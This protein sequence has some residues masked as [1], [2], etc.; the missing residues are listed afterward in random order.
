MFPQIEPSNFRPNKIVLCFQYI[1]THD[2]FLMTHFSLFRE[3]ESC[4]HIAGLLYG[5]VDLSEK[6]ADGLHSS[7]SRECWWLKPGKRKLSPK[8]S[9]ELTFKKHKFCN[10]PIEKTNC[11]KK[12]NR[13]EIKV[14]PVNISNFAA[15]LSAG[16]TDAAWLYTHKNFIPKKSLVNV[17]SDKELPQLHSINF[18]YRDS[19][20]LSSPACMENFNSYFSNLKISE[21]ESATILQ[22]T[23]GQTENPDWFKAREGRITASQFGNVCRRKQSTP[24]EGLLNVLMRYNKP[25][26][27]PSV[28]W[29]QSHENA[30]KRQY[31]SSESPKHNNLKCQESGLFVS[32][33]HPN[34]GAS[35]DGLISCECCGDGVL[36]IKC[37]FTWRFKHPSDACSDDNFYCRLNGD[38]LALKTSHIYFYQVQGQMALCQ[39]KYCDFV[40][41][42]LRG[43]M[44]ERIYFD[45]KFWSDCVEKINS[46]YVR[47]VLPEMFT[48][49]V[50][51][52]LKLY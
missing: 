1:F 42:T 31:I 23:V 20:D 8:K 4:S 9:D 49:R 32:T 29:G 19:L 3:G 6:K 46:F 24:P 51:R 26:E 44:I 21:S 14:K 41:W 45:P 11:A 52:G 12:S 18:M 30:A 33:D 38:Q 22:M 28:R 13:Q 25:Y 5:L 37:P 27:G 40:V 2:E 39:R 36:E 34:L 43:K 50:K 7:T 35:P 10:E 17:T 48:D 16:N 15:K 47:F